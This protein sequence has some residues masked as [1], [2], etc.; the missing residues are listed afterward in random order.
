MVRPD[1][2]R[3]L[4]HAWLDAA[5]KVA[6][7]QMVLALCGIEDA[8]CDFLAKQGISSADQFIKLPLDTGIKDL[9]KL[10]ATMHVPPTGT[11]PV[12][13]ATPGHNAATAAAA[14]AAAA[15]NAVCNQGIDISYMAWLNLCMLLMYMISLH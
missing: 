8:G 12:A 14:S 1:V 15:T 7:F 2:P 5:G 4:G 10:A 3:T 11:P 13:G 9:Q 6:Q